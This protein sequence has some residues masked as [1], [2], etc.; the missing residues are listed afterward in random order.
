MK[1]A[2][3]GIFAPKRLSPEL[4]AV[5]GGAEEMPRTEVTKKIW[6]YIKEH[7]L[8]EGRTVTPDEKLRKIFPVDN[9]DML[10]MAGYLSNHLFNI[11][12][13]EPAAQAVQ[14]ALAVAPGQGTAPRAVAA[15][16]RAAAERV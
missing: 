7:Q 5:C 13:S 16:A 15:A 2:A 1:T 10:Q 12:D 4:S 8:N 6:E 9:V 11:E 14:T 3:V